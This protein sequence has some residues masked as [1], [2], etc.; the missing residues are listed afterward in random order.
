VIGEKSEQRSESLRIETE[1]TSGMG[2]WEV[3]MGATEGTR[4][5]IRDFRVFFLKRSPAVGS[6]SLLVMNGWI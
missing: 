1:R 2:G 6:D 4:G 3:G 5:L